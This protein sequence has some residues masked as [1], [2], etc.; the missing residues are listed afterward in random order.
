M[1][2]LSIFGTISIENFTSSPK[3]EPRS[4]DP[5]VAIPRVAILLSSPKY[6]PKSMGLLHAKPMV[7]TFSSSSDIDV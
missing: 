5:F 6:D 7:V 3:L 4:V 2:A 1:G